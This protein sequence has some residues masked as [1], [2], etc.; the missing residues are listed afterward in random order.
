MPINAWDPCQWRYLRNLGKK[1][2]PCHPELFLV[3]KFV[4]MQKVLNKKGI[5][6]V[7]TILFLKENRQILIKILENFPHI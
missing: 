5:Y 2:K 1:E 6:S 4:K 7:T 3:Q